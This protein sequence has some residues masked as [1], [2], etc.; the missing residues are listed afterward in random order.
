MVERNVFIKYLLLTIDWILGAV[1]AVC[2]GIYS[3][4]FVIF[5]SI[6]LHGATCVKWVRVKS[7]Y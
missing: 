2:G 6:S 4:R 1:A 7:V 3:P 5:G